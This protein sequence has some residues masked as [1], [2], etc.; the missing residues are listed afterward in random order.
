MKCTVSP[1]AVATALALVSRA[2]SPRSTLPIL[3]N[4]LLETTP[5][6]LRLT[7][8]N[9]DLTITTTVPAEVVREGRVTVPARLVTEYIASLAE[10]PCTLELDPSTQVLRVTCGIHRTNIHGIDA[11]EFPPLPARD[12]EAT[13]SLDAATL[14]AA[15]GQTVVA[16]STDE[17]RPVLTGVLLQ[18]EGETVTL[19]A[20]DGHR[21][22]VRRLSP[23]GD[24]EG[25][26]P[27]AI[28]VIVPARHL[29]EVAR[30]ITANRPTVEVTL[31]ASRNHIFFTMRDVEVSSRL[32]EGAYPNYAQVIPSAQ[33]TTVTLASA[34]LL[35][36]TRTASILAKDAANV[37]RLAT[38][39]GTLTLHAQTAEVGDDEAPLTATV[40]GEGVQI[41]FNARYVLDALGVIDSEEVALG[42]NG[43]LSP[44]VI[45][46]VG[47]DDYLYIVM[48]VRVPM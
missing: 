42:F 31:A 18:L 28:S 44:G 24:G 14:D 19:A 10:A 33:T 15:I 41:A 37:V 4:V 38:G 47:R 3:S 7:A 2:V 30:A 40:D 22:A 34:T 17:A 11:V 16:A 43:P 9:L 25:E 5:E 20:T 26:A 45:R 8:T 48:P 27:A 1:T 12:A 23:K 21:L 6:G 46:P 39:E 36:E 13:V 35:R 29:G 32:I